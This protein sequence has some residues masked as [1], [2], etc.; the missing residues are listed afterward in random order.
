[1]TQRLEQL[2]Q[3][4][5]QARDEVRR[6][7]AYAL[8]LCGPKAR[9]AVPALTMALQDKHMAYMA[10]RALG[11]IGTASRAS[12]PDMA[13]LLASPKEEERRSHNGSLATQ[14]VTTGY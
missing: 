14:A 11:E 9:Q 12:I 5:N 4:L 10:A 7:A 3:L 1:M 13:A 6:Y 2:H 8:S